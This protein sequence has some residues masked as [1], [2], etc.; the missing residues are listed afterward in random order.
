[1]RWSQYLSVGTAQQVLFTPR[2][3][4]LLDSFIGGPG[5]QSNRVIEQL[6]V[7]YPLGLEC[8]LLER[9]SMPT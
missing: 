2:S 1:M 9:S 4:T 5:E 6:D 8:G 7:I 3:D